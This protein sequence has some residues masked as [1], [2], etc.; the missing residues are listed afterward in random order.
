MN[1]L[2]LPVIS[3]SLDPE[4]RSRDLATQAAELLKSAGHHAPVL[5]LRDHALPAFDN[6]SVFETEPFA[7]LHR[8]IAEADGIILATPIYNWAPSAA[9]KSLIEAT[10]ATGDDGTS[11]AWFDKVVT[12]LCAA[13][14]PQ[15]YMAT[16]QLASS[17]MLDF[18]CVINPYVGYFSSQE[19]DDDGGLVPDRQS[20]LEK[21]VAVHAELAAL[22]S[23]RSYSSNWEV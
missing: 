7:R 9:T 13:G 23:H 16:S 18:K 12:F 2:L 19:W 11:A 20:R 5:D 3:C 10:G 17:L 14:L 4:S 1:G 8:A 6:S 15:S 22:L 21:T